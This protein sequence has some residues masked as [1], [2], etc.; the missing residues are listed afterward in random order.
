MVT[1]DKCLVTLLMGGEKL[2]TFLLKKGE[3]MK[4]KLHIPTE[5]YGF[6]EVEFEAFSEDFVEQTYRQ[7]VNAFKPK[8]GLSDKDYNSFIDRYLLGELVHTEEYAA[9]STD[10]QKT[11]QII[12]RSLARIK[13]KQEKQNE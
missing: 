5:Q 7:V 1:I 12:K 2:Q 11:V 3:K 8:A 10:Q 6:V 9:M 13:S 4:Y